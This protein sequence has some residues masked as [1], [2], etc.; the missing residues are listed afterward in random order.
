MTVEEYLATVLRPFQPQLLLTLA[1]SQLG[2]HFPIIVTVQHNPSSRIS[3]W[4]NFW[5]RTCLLRFQRI[6]PERIM[7][8]IKIK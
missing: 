4:P 8:I 2:K 1:S 5:G 6:V 3:G 7:A